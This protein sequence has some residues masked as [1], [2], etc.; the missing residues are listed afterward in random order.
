MPL[1][2][3][4]KHQG[5]KYQVYVDDTEEYMSFRPKD[6]VGKY[7]ALGCINNLLTITG[8]NSIL[9]KMGVILY[10]V[11]VLLSDDN[12]RRSE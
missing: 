3:T 12:K 11:S 2:N 4:F 9:T 7:L 8:L 6:N 1:W 5:Q 10:I